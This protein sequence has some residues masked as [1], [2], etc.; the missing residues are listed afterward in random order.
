M[1]DNRLI[2][3][4]IDGGFLSPEQ[5]EALLRDAV[6]FARSVEEI[7]ASKN[8]VSE[9]DLA[10]AKSRIL[11]VPYT[12]VNL[13]TIPDDLLQLI[14]E[15]TAKT[16]EVVPLHREGSTLIVG[17]VHPDN[18][19]TQEVLRFVAKQNKVSMG[20]YVITPSD[21]S[22]VLRKYSPFENTFQSAI[23]SLNIKPDPTK[24][25]A[26]QRIVG[27]EDRGIGKNEEAP[28]IKIVASILKE[29][30][31][32]GASDIHIEPQRKSLRVRL[33]VDGELQELSSMPVELHQPILSR[34]KV[35]SDLKI[36]E[37]RAPQDGRFRTN[38]FGREIDFRVST[39]PTPA[40]EKVALRVLDPET[41]LKSLD[42]LGLV[43][44]NREIVLTS[45]QRPY[46]M[47][48]ITGPTG[49]G[50]TTTLYAIMQILNRIGV[51]IVSLEDPVE[52][53]IDGI[54][55]SQVH[56]EIG[57]D[58]ASGLRQ[59]LRQDPDVI[60]VGEI[61]DSETAELAV[62]AALT[63]HVVLST[64]HTNDSVGVIPRLTD[65]K[66]EPFLLPSALNLMLAQRLVSQLC[67]KCAKPEP[68][69]EAVS[70]IIE[71][72]L[73]KLPA[74]LS[75]KF[76]KPYQVYRASGCPVCKGKGIVGRIAIFEVF[77]MTPQLASIVSAGINE[78]KIAEE[79]KRQGMVS[80]RQDGILKALAG[81]VSIEDVIR[82]TEEV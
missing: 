33:R 17:M 34:V 18:Q 13:S 37:T 11:G 12:A 9:K 50:K 55:Q 77:Q 35:M 80:L 15:E 19:K 68:A 51:N 7:I 8:L 21:L 52:Y 54:N 65:M 3:E 49:S 74:A 22:L 29:A 75:Q 28:V 6:N 16:Y 44:R 61:R 60:M 26:G 10:Q 81:T 47:V 45:I 30:V 64:L 27:L 20:A 67:E 36:D 46:G 58:F 57:Y 23:R 48:L 31:N 42:A 66:V 25:A 70:Q 71:K 40:G 38:I 43:G 72:D 32:L 62:H 39:F 24:G 5:G 78:A 53:T 56:P 59:I 4:L 63:G 79:A 73:S 76:S 41:G 1:D 14:P 82:E 2:K 69:S